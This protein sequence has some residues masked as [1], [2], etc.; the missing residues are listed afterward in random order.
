MIEYKEKHP[1]LKFDDEVDYKLHYI[2]ND[3]K[4]TKL[5]TNKKN[6]TNSKENTINNTIKPYCIYFPQF[7]EMEEN[8]FSFYEKKRLCFN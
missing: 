8:N 6:N 4:N 1:E 5:V 2:R 7:H 3:Y